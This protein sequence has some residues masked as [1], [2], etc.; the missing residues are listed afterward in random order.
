MRQPYGLAPRY[1]AIG[2]GKIGDEMSIKKKYIVLPAA[3]LLLTASLPSQSREAAHGNVGYYNKPWNVVIGY[4]SYGN[5]YNRGHRHG[6][7]CGHYYKRHNY[8][9]KKH[10][11]DRHRNRHQ[12]NRHH[13]RHG[14]RDR[15]Y[16]RSHYYKHREYRKHRDFRDRNRSRHW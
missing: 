2:S 16:N 6:R 15:H 12:Y 3:I 14:Y 5:H 9:H 4:N 10:Y 7:S 11:Y 1:I 13:Y 8:K